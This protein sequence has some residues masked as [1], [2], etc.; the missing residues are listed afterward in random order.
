VHHRARAH[1]YSKF[2]AARFLNGFLDLVAVSFIQTASLKPLHVFGRIGLGLILLGVLIESVFFAQ[3]IFGEPLRVR[4]L[5]VLGAVLVILG[6][7]F[8]SMGLLGEMIATQQPKTS[9]PLRATHRW[10]DD[11]APPAR[12]EP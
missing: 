6:I 8:G 2:G 3:W 11:E 7:Q 12:P 5:L 1:G 4:P 10:N 9:F